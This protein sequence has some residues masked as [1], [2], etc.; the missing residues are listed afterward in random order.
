MVLS[1]QELA[2]RALSTLADEERRRSVA[3]LD[4]RIVPPG[5]SLEIDGKEVSVDR[6][7]A[8]AFVDLEPGVNWGHR[9]RYLLIDAE[10]GE[11]QTVPAQFPPF[12]R[13]VPDSLRPIWRGESVPEW[14]VAQ[15]G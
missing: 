12:L 4:E 3:Y 11:T 9:S 10:T 7:T 14:A 2:G 1:W 8:V 13:Q 15:P 5:A 6:P